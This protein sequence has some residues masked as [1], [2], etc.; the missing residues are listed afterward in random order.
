MAYTR[1]MNDK[2]FRR[3]NLKTSYLPQFQPF[4]SAAQSLEYE[5]DDEVLEVQKADNSTVIIN[6]PNRKMVVWQCV[7]PNRIDIPDNVPTAHL[8]ICKPGCPNVRY[9][10]PESL[11]VVGRYKYLVVP[12][13]CA[14]AELCGDD[15]FNAAYQL[16]NQN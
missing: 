16:I 14:N 5:E 7:P 2:A 3:I 10:L 9:M 1:Q 6:K 11:P 8:G 15:Y 12:A 4:C 13:G